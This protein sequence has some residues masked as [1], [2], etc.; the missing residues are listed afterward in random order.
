MNQKPV[1]EKAWELYIILATNGKLYTGIALNADK[2]FHEHLCSNKGAKFF[3]STKPVAIVY[4]E[5]HENRSSALQREI[6]IKKL[7][8]TQKMALILTRIMH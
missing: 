7:N 5:R 6:A 1:N 2:R 8:R 4:R 3:R